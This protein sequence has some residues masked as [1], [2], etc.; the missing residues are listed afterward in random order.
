MKQLLLASWLDALKKVPHDCVFHY[1]ETGYEHSVHT[2]FLCSE[3]GLDPL[4]GLLHDIGKIATVSHRL[5]GR[6][7]ERI[8]FFNHGEVGARWLG[9]PDIKKKL[10]ID[11]N[12]IEDVR[13]HLT[14]Y[15]QNSRHTDKRTPLRDMFHEVD[16][17]AGKPPEDILEVRKIM[18]M[19]SE[20]LIDWIYERRNP[21]G[22]YPYFD[23]YIHH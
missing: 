19:D 6:G 18:K 23:S 3:R 14:P 16:R 7:R 5:D 21:D 10:E 11:D 13:W 4:L 2:A 20:A 9:H 15:L 1:G 12:F 8:S 22:V 17:E